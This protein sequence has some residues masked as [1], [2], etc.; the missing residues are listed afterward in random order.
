MNEVFIVV[1]LNEDDSVAEIVSAHPTEQVAI[2]AERFMRSYDRKRVGD[3][4]TDV[5]N[6]SFEV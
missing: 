2:S 3:R 5:R 1:I 4:H 6:V